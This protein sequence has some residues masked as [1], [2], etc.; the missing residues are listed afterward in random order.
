MA[1]RLRIEYAGALYH[2]LNR[3]IDRRALFRDPRDFRRFLENLQAGV[4]THQAVLHAWVLLPNHYHLL[5][6]TPRGNLSAFMQ[7][8]QTQYAVY[9]NRRHRKSGHVF[10]GPYKGILVE[11]DRYLL[12][13][14]R[15]IHLNP[16]TT[17][18]YKDKPM[19]EVIE[20][21]RK[22]PWSS[23]RGYVRLEKRIDWACYERLD[24]QAQA[25]F[26]KQKGGYRKYVE[27]GLAETDEELVEAMKTG[28]LAV[29]SG[30]FVEAMKDRY[31]R[32][33]EEGSQ[34]TEDVSWRKERRLVEP[35]EILRAVCESLGI[36]RHELTQRRGGAVW[37]GI[38]ARMLVKYGALTQRAVAE[39]LGVTTGAAIS[40]RLKAAGE[41]IKAQRSLRRAVKR[42]ENTLE[43]HHEP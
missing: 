29:G 26:G 21:L 6:E 38:A 8:V 33:R 41:A 13:L 27:R 24:G 15:Y 28:S 1:R 7:A 36:G 17:K 10:Q 32:L 39:E 18:V 20:A 4:Q 40:I 11:E 30:E 12:K 19:R 31:R 42:I 43:Q 14:S 16:V 35:E 37:R 25:W 34:R 23:Y 22:Y 5:I 3:G 2:V 9:Y